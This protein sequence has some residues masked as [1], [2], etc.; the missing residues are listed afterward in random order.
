[1]FKESLAAYEDALKLGE[2]ESVDGIRNIG[3]DFF[4]KK[5]YKKALTCYQL[6]LKYVPEDIKAREDVKEVEGLILEP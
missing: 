4:N 1:M 5:E 2:R 3:Y 6:I